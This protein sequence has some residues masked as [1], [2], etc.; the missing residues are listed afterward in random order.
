MK[1]LIVLSCAV[2]FMTASAFASVNGNPVQKLVNE[3]SKASITLTTDQVTTMENMFENSF[4]TDRT[5][6]TSGQKGTRKSTRAKSR[7]AFKKSVYENVLTDAQKQK[8][9]AYKGR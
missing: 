3:F 4:P 9:R 8:Y 6:K 1:K 5:V 2:L 7:K